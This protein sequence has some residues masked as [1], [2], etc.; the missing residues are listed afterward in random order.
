MRT[1]TIFLIAIALIF[2]SCKKKNDISPV[3]DSGGS[4]HPN[5]GM[6]P[7][8]L[9]YV[10]VLEFVPGCPCADSTVNAELTKILSYEPV[11]PVP[12]ICKKYI[13]D[14]SLYAR[15]FR[16]YSDSVVFIINDQPCFYQQIESSIDAV[17]SRTPEAQSN[18]SMKKDGQNIS[19][20]VT[21]KFFNSESNADYYLAA[22]AL[23]DNIPYGKRKI[24]HMLRAAS[25]DND[26]LGEKIVS[27]SVT[28]GT[29]ITKEYTIHCP[30]VCNMSNMTVATFIWKKVNGVVT[31]VN[32]FEKK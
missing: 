31:F 7:Q 11:W 14:D 22:Y 23:E 29:E 24:S 19:V 9:Q 4:Q 3:T 6:V 13:T 27:G 21:T 12:V 25:V 17:L 20:T 2:T 30:A 26:A 28:A 18:F 5:C 1:T 15:M 16:I 32:A 8:Q 10:G